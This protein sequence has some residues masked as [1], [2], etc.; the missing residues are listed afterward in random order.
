MR[1]LLSEL[2][3][4]PL[5]ILLVLTIVVAIA[6]W[7]LVGD[8]FDPLRR[9]TITGLVALLAVGIGSMLLLL[10]LL[11][12]PLHERLRRTVTTNAA[13]SWT[14]EG[15]LAG[16]PRPAFGGWA[17]EPDVAV[18]L[19]RVVQS[20]T[21]SLVV[22]LGPGATT[23]LLIS[24]L[25]EDTELVAIE[26]DQGFISGLQERVRA[27]DGPVPQLRH[28]PLT[29]QRLPGWTGRWY[30]PE[31]FDDLS[32]IDLLLVDGPPGNRAFNARFPAVPLLFERLSPGARILVDD[33]GRP[34]DRAMIDRWIGDYP[35]EV[36]AQGANY[37]LLKV[38]SL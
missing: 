7:W 28:A 11:A 24:L 27:Y 15:E 38:S 32:G 2:G 3:R 9:L 6:T 19:V 13:A 20:R 1:R 35:L 36:S 33:S 29:R 23:E 10:G 4:T 25:P 37:R 26:H 5:L 16:E 18:A 14:L 17:I 21:P 12:G 34:D 30:S 22:E 8:A 31:A